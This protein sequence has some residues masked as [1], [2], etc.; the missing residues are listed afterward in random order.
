MA[1]LLIVADRQH[2]K[3][4][5]LGTAAWLLTCTVPM[6]AAAQQRPVFAD[7]DPL[8]KAMTVRAYQIF[9]QHC[10]GL[11]KLSPLIRQITVTDNAVVLAEGGKTRNWTIGISVE[12]RVRD[13]AVENARTMGTLL[14]NDYLFVVGAGKDPGIVSM[15]TTGLQLC[16]PNDS[17]DFMPAREARFLKEWPSVV[18]DD[19][20]HPGRRLDDTVAPLEEGEDHRRP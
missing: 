19:K 9:V 6:P 12:V 14:M 20:A 4:G 15:A 13:T 8:D 11:A 16:I 7:I 10:P 1:N 2:R 5:V 18:A 3:A 17:S